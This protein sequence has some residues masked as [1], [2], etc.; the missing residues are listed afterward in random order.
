M[1][2]KEGLRDGGKPIDRAYV[3]MYAEILGGEYDHDQSH[4]S[5]GQAL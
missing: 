3:F 5:E 4:G 1:R 2:K